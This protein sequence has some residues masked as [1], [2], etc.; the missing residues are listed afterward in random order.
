MAD[1]SI[2]MLNNHD[3]KKEPDV[4]GNN[5]VCELPDECKEMLIA[6]Y[7]ALREEILKRMELRQGIISI[8][9]TFAAAFLVAGVEFS[10][11]IVFIYIPLAALLTLVWAQ[12]DVRIREIA[13]YIRN[14]IENNLK[15]LSWERKMSK[16]RENA[17]WTWKKIL[18]FDKAYYSLTF[19]HGGIFLL[20]QLIAL[21]IGL[22]K[23]FSES[24]RGS[25]DNLLIGILIVIDF[26]SI[27]CVYT[28]LRQ[29]HDEIHNHNKDAVYSDDNHKNEFVKCR[30]IQK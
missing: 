1:E 18:L 28:T 7:M 11:S 3:A 5:N 10:P 6:E 25:S 12:N 15:C 23:I 24:N 30:S 27:F 17:S 26:Y 14:H 16:D 19:S 4:V 29:I 2:S 13:R 22:I 20:T 8:T 9:L 21:I